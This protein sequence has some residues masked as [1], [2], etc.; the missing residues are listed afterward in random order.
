MTTKQKAVNI[1]AGLSVIIIVAYLAGMRHHGGEATAPPTSPPVAEATLWTCSMH[2]EIQLP[3]P[4]KCPKCA[5]D[6]IPLSGHSELK[7][8]Q[9]QLTK[10]AQ[11]LAKIVTTRVAEREIHM[12]LEL[13]GKLNVD[14]TKVYEVSSRFPARLD[15]LFVDYTGL[16]VNKGDHMVTAYSPELLSAQAELVQSRKAVDRLTKSASPI[17]RDS[18]IATLKAAREK[19]RLWGMTATQID[20]AETGKATGDHVTLFAP[21]SGIVTGKYVNQ[22]DY[23]KEGTRI[24]SITDLSRLWLELDAYESDLAWIHYA[25]EVE[26]HTVAFPGERFTGIIS[27]IHP[28]LNDKTRTVK[29]R[30]NVKNA[31]GRLKPNMYV[32]AH[33]KVTIKRDGTMINNRMSG[34]WISPMHPEIIKDGPGEC[35][36]CGMDLVPAEKLGFSASKTYPKPLVIPASAALVTGKRAIVYV[37]LPEGVFEGRQVRLGPKAGHHY[38][39][40]DGLKKGDIVVT[41]GAFKV[42]SSLQLKAKRSMMSPDETVTPKEKRSEGSGSEGSHSEGSHSEGSHSEGSHSEGSHAH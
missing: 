22:G 2:P 11:E 8:N 6:L 29:I 12:D 23:V 26:F 7:S 3:N 24:Y 18:A 42:D 9:I 41:H 15:R 32:G 31:D 16:K 40:L 20:D 38:I 30:V 13:T 17:I 14:E 10:H 37:Q 33:I 34:K 36:I 4:G 19:L 21:H 35:D 27:F 25:Q 39:V 1:G 5:M 28:V